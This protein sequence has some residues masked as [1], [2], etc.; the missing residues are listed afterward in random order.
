MMK[1][2]RFLLLMGMIAPLF[3]EGQDTRPDT[4]VI[5]GITVIR[6]NRPPKNEP[7]KGFFKNINSRRTLKK[8]T[9]EWGMVDIGMSSFVDRTDY[10]GVAAQAYAPGSNNQWFETKGFKSRN[11]NLWV[12]TQRYSLVHHVLNLQYG[13]GLELNNYFYTQPVRYD[14]NPPATQDPPVVSIDA[15]AQSVPPERIY[16]KDKLAADYVTVPLMLNF[17]FTP[18]RIYPFEL[19]AGVSIG[20]LYASRNKTITSDEGKQKAKDA[21]GLKPW[22]LSYVGDLTL[23]VVTFYGSYAFKG[24][25]KR[26]LDMTP[27][28]FG[29]RLRPGDLFNKIE[30]R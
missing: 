5:N 27:Y 13:V 22:K 7:K 30:N 15:R 26:G 17:N 3:V 6:D 25:Y 2:I 16:K 21:F 29:I 18:D 1:K 11:I 20:Y 12:V 19:S 14:P 4:L 10:P 24:M 28:T 23:G 9:T 8:I